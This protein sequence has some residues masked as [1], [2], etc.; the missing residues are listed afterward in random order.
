MFLTKKFNFYIN[1]ITFFINI[2]HNKLKLVKQKLKCFRFSVTVQHK[3][4]KSIIHE[5][6]QCIIDLFFGAE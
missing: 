2:I 6:A 1:Y 4:D 5:L 3:K